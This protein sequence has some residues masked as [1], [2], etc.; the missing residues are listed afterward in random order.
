[1]RRIFTVENEHGQKQALLGSTLLLSLAL[2]RI[3]FFALRG[4]LHTD[5]ALTAAPLSFLEMERSSRMPALCVRRARAQSSAH[6]RTCAG[7]LEIRFERRGYV[8]TCS[9][10][11]GKPRRAARAAF[12]SQ[13]GARSL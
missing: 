13:K 2:I 8:W 3:I 4:Q 7:G 11:R 6:P 9:I 12:L 5:T 1:M 10:G